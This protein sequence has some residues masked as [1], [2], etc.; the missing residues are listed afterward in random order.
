MSDL[1]A[2]EQELSDAIM[3]EMRQIMQKKNISLKMLAEKSGA[4]L[5]TV[6]QLAE[7]RLDIALDE[8]MR[9]L[10]VLGLTLKVMPIEA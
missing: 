1:Q 9:V 10:H 6:E 4:P 8:A 3:R 2:M 7:G 5:E